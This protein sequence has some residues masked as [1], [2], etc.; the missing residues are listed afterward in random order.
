MCVCGAPRSALYHLSAKSPQ[1]SS[2]PD[3]Q[4]SL[5]Y[6]AL[7]WVQV[8]ELGMGNGKHTPSHQPSSTVT[9]SSQSGDELPCIWADWLVRFSFG[10]VGEV[11]GPLARLGLAHDV[12]SLGKA[13]G[14]E[15]C[16]N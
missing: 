7:S 8:G 5:S 4:S 1:L 9:P 14:M 2:S 15:D 16:M 3:G 12:W 6:S 10:A 11:H 13:T